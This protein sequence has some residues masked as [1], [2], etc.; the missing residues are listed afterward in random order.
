MCAAVLPVSAAEAVC[1]VAVASP[2][3]APSARAAAVGA[4]AA[5]SGVGAK[6]APTSKATAAA[7]PAAAA[8]AAAPPAAGTAAAPSVPKVKG[9]GDPVRIA[10]ARAKRE[11]ELAASGGKAAISSK[12]ISGGST[13]GAM[14]KLKDG[15]EG[16]VVTRF[17]PE[18]SGFLHIGHV[19]ALLLNEF[20]AKAYK[21]K[22]LIRFD[23]TNPRCVRN[24]RL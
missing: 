14:L 5:V 6:A 2:S 9:E 4:A 11:A 7:A 10:A 12:N 20:Y 1:G 19:K 21:G 16:A 13:T 18:P 15:V 8:S 23:D 17:P 3:A 22:M 24:R